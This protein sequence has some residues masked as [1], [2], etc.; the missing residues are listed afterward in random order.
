MSMQFY[1]NGVEVVSQLQLRSQ[2]G[3]DLSPATAL[4]SL[5]RFDGI[6]VTYPNWVEWLKIRC[7]GWIS[8]RTVIGNTAEVKMNWNGDATGESYDTNHTSGHTCGICYTGALGQPPNN[9]FS[10]MSP[11]EFVV[12]NNIGTSITI[13]IVDAM[14][15]QTLLNWNTDFALYFE[16]IPMVNEKTHGTHG[17]D[18]GQQ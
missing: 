14:D 9:E 8:D 7:V 1:K 10:N 3:V 15:G 11:F 17:L 4:K 16:I 13:S 5:F 18:I 2:N 12:A 6:G